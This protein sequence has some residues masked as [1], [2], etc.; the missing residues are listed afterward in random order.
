MLFIFFIF[1]ITQEYKKRLFFK[2]RG[3]PPIV[4]PGNQPVSAK[5][6]AKVDVIIF[7]IFIYMSLYLMCFLFFLYSE[8]VFVLFYLFG[9]ISKATRKSNCFLIFK[10]FRSVERS[11]FQKS[12]LAARSLAKI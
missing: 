1:P 7:K 11:V 8:S 3:S 2:L 5:S 9:A 4:A 6:V 12:T 10:N